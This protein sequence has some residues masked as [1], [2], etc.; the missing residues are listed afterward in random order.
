LDQAAYNTGSST[1][2]VTSSVTTTA[3]GELVLAYC[4]GGNGYGAGTGYTLIDNSTGD[5]VEFA[6]QSTAGSVS[7]GFTT[8]VNAAWFCNIWTFLPKP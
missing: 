2:P 3:N 1:N 7:A 4:T 5:T 6:V 8:A